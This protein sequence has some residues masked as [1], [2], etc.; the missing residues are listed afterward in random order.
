MFKTLAKLLLGVLFAKAGP[1][2]Q[3]AG[4][5]VFLVLIGAGSLVTG[6][7]RQHGGAAPSLQGPVASA[8]GIGVVGVGLVLVFSAS[9]RTT[10]ASEGNQNRSAESAGPKGGPAAPSDSSQAGGGRPSAR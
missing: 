1:R 9:R 10:K 8:L 2:F 4:L 5:G 7:V 6:T 3:K